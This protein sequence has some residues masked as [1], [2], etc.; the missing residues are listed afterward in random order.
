M[1]KER[2]WGQGRRRGGVEEEELKQREGREEEERRRRG[3]GRAV[4]EHF[5]DIH[6]EISKGR[7][8]WESGGREGAER[9]E[10]GRQLGKKEK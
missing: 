6:H 2:L 1:S 5:P 3:G 7:W 10:G 9:E 4:G 8:V